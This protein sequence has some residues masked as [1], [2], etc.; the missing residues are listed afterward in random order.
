MKYYNGAYERIIEAS[1]RAPEDQ[2]LFLVHDVGNK[3]DKDAI[4]LHDGV[5]K[6]GHIAAS[7]CGAVRAFLSKEGQLRGQ[8][9]VLVAYVPTIKNDSFSWS[10]SFS[11]KAV[12]LINERVAR[13][14]AATI[15]KKE[16]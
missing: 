11:V 4:M 3:F 6:L 10:T 12:G 1:R 2:C 14:F 16:S 5:S 9:V 15:S 8:D 7:E 13:K